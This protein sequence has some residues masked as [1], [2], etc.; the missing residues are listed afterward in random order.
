[1]I[2]LSVCI[3]L[4]VPAI[5]NAVAQAPPATDT[6]VLLQ[7]F[8]QTDATGQW[9]L[10]TP[11]PVTALGKSS[12]V[13]RLTG[14]SSLWNRL[15]GQY[16]EATGQ[17]S[18]EAVGGY[19]LTVA[20]MKRVDPPGTMHRDYN[21]GYTKHAR[22]TLSVV[23]NR[24]AWVRDGRSTGVNPT[25]I[26]TVENQSNN[27]IFIVMHKD[28]LVC[29]SIRTPDSEVTLWDS[30]TLAPLP[31]RRRFVFQHGGPFLQVFQ[32]PA[33]VVSRP[34]RYEVQIGICE[35]DDYDMTAVFDVAP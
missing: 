34:G 29:M 9:T 21:A 13:M 25:V 19:A 4:L 33:Q 35:I 30:T 12:Y 3:A 32:L 27:P 24:F 5:S 14:N 18:T 23:P 11:L 8:V 6:A 17:L 1:M 31:N 7:G 15:E 28:D 16:V 10:V 20:G 26:Y 2:R 22:M